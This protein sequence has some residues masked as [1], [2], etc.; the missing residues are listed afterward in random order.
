[1]VALAFDRYF[2]TAGLFGTVDDGLEVV[3]GS[4]P[5]GSTRSRASSTSAWPL[6][7]C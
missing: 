6:M 1:M 2:T 5:S 7:T 3:R 4:R